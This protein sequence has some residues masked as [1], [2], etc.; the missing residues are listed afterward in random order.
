MTARDVS[1]RRSA[2]LFGRTQVDGISK[3]YG[4]GFADND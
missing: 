1:F 3:Q 4:E 2:L